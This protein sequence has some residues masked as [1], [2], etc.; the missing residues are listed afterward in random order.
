VHD[1]R[2][3]HVV[4]VFL[5][6]QI[7]WHNELSLQENAKYFTTRSYLTLTQHHASRNRREFVKNSFRL[8]STDSL[9]VCQTGE[10]ISFY[11]LLHGIILAILE[12]AKNG[13]KKTGTLF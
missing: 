7:N 2:I 1:Y 3:A 8:P 5:Y 12:N 11:S 4:E 10:G 13:R 6:Q 9:R